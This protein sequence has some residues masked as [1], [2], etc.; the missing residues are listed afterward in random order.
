M[1]AQSGRFYYHFQYP[2][3]KC[4]VKILLYLEEEVASL[5]AHMNCIQKQAIVKPP[6]QIIT[7]SPGYGASGCNSNKTVNGVRMIDC[8]S[9]RILRSDIDRNWYIA[10]SS[11]GSPDGLDLKYS[12]VMYGYRGECPEG[13]SLYTSAANSPHVTHHFCLPSFI[14]LFCIYMLIVP[15]FLRQQGTILEH[16]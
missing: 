12:L 14:P 5:R 13:S 4:C 11:C 3:H 1:K 10:A 15:M 8:T 9:G 7:L 2:D 16:R 6:Q